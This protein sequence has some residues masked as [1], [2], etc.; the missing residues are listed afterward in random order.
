[1]IWGGIVYD[2]LILLFALLL[3]LLLD[4]KLWL[5]SLFL[6][7][8]IF[9]SNVTHD[10]YSFLVGLSLQVTDA[11][12]SCVCQPLNFTAG[13]QNYSSINALE[14][15]LFRQPFVGPF[16]QPHEHRRIRKDCLLA[17]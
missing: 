11:T 2:L 9:L 1:M 8:F 15:N 17:W 4:I 7:T 12:P 16:D 6:I 14:S 3:A 10:D 13:L 5:F